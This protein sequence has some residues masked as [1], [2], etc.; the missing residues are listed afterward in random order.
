MKRI[1][2]ALYFLFA[3]AAIAGFLSVTTFAEPPRT[4]ARKPAKK[5]TDRESVPS[6]ANQKTENRSRS[7]DAQSGAAQ[8]GSSAEKREAP[9]SKDREDAAV[10]FARGH[11]P[12]LA[13]LLEGLRETDPQNFQAGLRALTRDAER[14]GKMLERKDER[15]PVSLELW[16]LDSRIR[17]EIARMSMSPG[18]DFE[19]RLRPLMENRQAARVRLIQMERLRTVERLAKYDEQL[20]TLQSQSTDLVGSEIERLKKVVAAQTRTKVTRPQTP[21]EPTAATV[22]RKPSSSKT[23]RSADLRSTSSD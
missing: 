6:A 13:E 1:Q 4:V 12:E 15:Y 18:E 7:E 9:I 16:K 11:H 17:L 14:L 3:G 2:K 22:R 5:V 20:K 8:S 10:R 23:S 19:P 21:K